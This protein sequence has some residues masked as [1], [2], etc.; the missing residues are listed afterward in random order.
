MII[1]DRKVLAWHFDVHTYTPI[2]GAFWAVDIQIPEPHLSQRL[3]D[4][5]GLFVSG[6]PN[7]VSVTRTF[8][9]IE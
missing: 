3:D 1:T 7:L 8:R 5:V 2:R 9:G 6:H 4:L